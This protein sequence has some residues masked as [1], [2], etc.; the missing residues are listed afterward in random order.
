V[1]AVPIQ[2]VTVRPP[3]GKDGA[4]SPAAKLEKVVFVVKDGV[5][6]KRKVATGLSSDQMVEITSGLTEG[7]SVVE[8]PYRILA[9]ELK[10]GD[11]VR[12]MPPRGGPR[13]GGPPGGT[14]ARR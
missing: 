3:D 12:S 9:R 7:E 10:H 2:A 14:A 8:G 6:E 1:L 5:V 13:G 11:A 4:P